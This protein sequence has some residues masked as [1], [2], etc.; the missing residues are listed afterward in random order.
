MRLER[1]KT[2]FIFKTQF[3]LIEMTGLKAA[4]LRQL[5]DFLEQV[6]ESSV[7]YH[8]HHFLR[9]HQFVSP[10]PPNDFAYWVTH[11]LQEGALG[12]QLAAVDVIRFHTLTSLREAF[13][14]VIDR[15]LAKNTE[16]RLAPLGMEFHFMQCVLFT[17]PTP[18]VAG[19]LREFA[20]CIR[21]ID[22]NCFYNHVFESYLRLPLGENDFSSWLKNNLGEHDLAREIDRLD[23]YTQTIEGLRKKMVWLIEKRLGE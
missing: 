22:G 6:P 21:Q 23:P 19:N 3:S 12:E 1:A 8:T 2:P 13:V 16:L 17:L 10:E 14:S 4:S 7:Y 18:Y 20:A 5:R 9:Q 15:F 11:V